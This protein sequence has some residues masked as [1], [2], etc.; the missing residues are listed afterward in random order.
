MNY[1]GLDLTTSEKKAS[2]YATLDRN[3]RLT[4]CGV[5]TTD[6][7]IRE[8]ALSNSAAALGIDCPL[9]LPAG[10]HCLEEE[11]PRE[12]CAPRSTRKGR[13]GE[14]ELARRGISC[15]FTTKRS[16]IKAMVYRGMALSEE[17]T[18]KGLNVL[19]VYPY[20][21]KVALW[22]KPIPKKTGHCGKQFMQ[23]RL[24]HLIPGVASY[25]GTLTHDHYDATI[26]AY[27][28]YLHSRGETE[29]L[30]IQ[31]EA[32]IVVPKAK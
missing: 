10:L 23:E 18:N 19:E 3:G 12:W 17:L 27:T 24:G 32:S 2:A 26:A 30:G 6:G 1:L 21:S 22:G 16:I 15:Y 8:W 29:G 13:E 9:G 25:A 14:R 7:E 11:C 31:E 20:A 4:D 28:A 5:L